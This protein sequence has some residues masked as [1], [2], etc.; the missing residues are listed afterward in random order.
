MKTLLILSF[1]SLISVSVNA[2]DYELVYANS[3]P[4]I[5]QRLN[6]NKIS[7]I[8][9]LTGVNA[10]HRVGLSGLTQTQAVELEQL[11]SQHQEIISFRLND[12]LSD[13]WLE[14]QASLSKVDVEDIISGFSGVITGYT[15]SYSLNY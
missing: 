11:L 14:S 7:G 2:Q 9:I 15:I 1:L 4:E 12:D 13:L 8:D 3:T 6:E 5:Q 10:E